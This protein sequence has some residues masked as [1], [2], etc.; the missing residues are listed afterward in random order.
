M[1]NIQNIFLKNKD[2]KGIPSLNP[3]QWE[4]LNSAYDK[5]T[6]I[7]ELIEY[8]KEHKPQAPTLPI[9]K[10]EMI[11]NFFNLKQAPIS[12]FI[13]TFEETKGRVIEKYDDYGHTYDDCG[14]GVVQMGNGYLD[15]SNYFNQEL[16]LNCDTYGFKSAHYRWNNVEDLRTV[17]LALWRL[18]NDKLDEQSI[19]GAFRLSTYIATQFK[20][21]VAKYVYNATNSKVIFDSSCGWGDRLAGFYCSNAKEYYGCDPND[22]TF[23]MYKQQCIMYETILGGTPVI[24]ESKDF[25][26]CIGEKV[27]YLFRLPA[28]DLNY[29]FM[30]KVDCAFTS[31]PYF[32]T[33]LYNSGGVHEDDQ[34][35][36]RYNTY[37]KWRDNFYLPV[38]RKTYEILNDGGIQIVNIQDPK[39][40]NT[41]YYAS[42][43]L[44]NDLTTKYSDCKFLGNL[45]MRIMQRPKNIDKK[46][47]LAHFDKIYIEPMW[48]F[49]KNRNELSKK[50]LGLSQFM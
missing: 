28:E 40:K 29:N 2:A 19:V 12:K 30:P 13:L 17:F 9:T 4:E 3:K 11:T 49:G 7:S 27:V 24:R 45:G 33:E 34:S 35:W 37:E 21:H 15:V 44:I 1:E 10:E 16:R 47:L 42:D 43:D 41:R 25:F 22:Q 18:G 32:S 8:I 46:K 50:G 38:N 14:L 26:S 36:K 31:P 5:E 23:E 6:I 48:C 20:P 39:V